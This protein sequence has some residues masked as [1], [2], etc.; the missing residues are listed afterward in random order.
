VAN[1]ECDDKE[2]S[3]HKLPDEW[4]NFDQSSRKAKVCN[5]RCN[6]NRRADG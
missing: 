4:F 5:V 2:Y 6:S 3:G 1:K